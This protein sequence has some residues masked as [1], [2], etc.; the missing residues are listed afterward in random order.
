MDSD[1][2]GR[3]IVLEVQGAQKDF[4]KGDLKDELKSAGLQDCV[5]DDIAD[6]VNER[7]IEGW[8]QSMGRQ[9]ALKEIEMFIQRAKQGY[10]NFKQRNMPSPEATSRTTY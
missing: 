3:L 7:K 4:D 10:E 9:E 1:F 2:S 8:T 5:V 6:R